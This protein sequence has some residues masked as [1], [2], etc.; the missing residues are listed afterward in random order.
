MAGT[1]FTV[2]PGAR[3]QQGRTGPR[4]KPPALPRRARPGPR[5]GSVHRSALGL[6]D[7]PADTGS[8]T[9]STTTPVLR[10]VIV[11]G[12]EGTGPMS[13]K[14]LPPGDASRRDTAGPPRATDRRP[15]P[16]TVPP[17]VA[18]EVAARPPR[19]AVLPFLWVAFAGVSVAVFPGGPPAG[20]TEHFVEG[21]P[22]EALIRA[23]GAGADPRSRTGEGA[24][25]RATAT[26]RL[27]AVRTTPG[28][29]S[30]ARGCA[31]DPGDAVVGADDGQEVS[32]PQGAG[33]VRVGDDVLAADDAGTGVAGP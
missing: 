9:R 12:S 2:S 1:S 17:A 8:R 18:G 30:R 21:D 10:P 27:S 22:S 16:A 13:T 3:G 33:P 20:L 26:G 6:A 25:R 19:Y 24:K 29:S 28:S 11:T 31:P 7:R 5:T 4:R 14:T 23:P 32:C 15:R